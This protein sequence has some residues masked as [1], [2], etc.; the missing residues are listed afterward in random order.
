MSEKVKRPL[1]RPPSAPPPAAAEP[2]L[3]HR[4]VH[5]QNLLVTFDLAHADL[6]GELGGGGAVSFQREGTVQGLLVAAPHLGEGEFLGRRR[7]RK[8]RD[9]SN[10]LYTK[11]LTYAV[12]GL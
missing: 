4:C 11:V 5:L 9:V 12:G 10:L 3:G 7:K 2:H 6:A 8:R 1:H